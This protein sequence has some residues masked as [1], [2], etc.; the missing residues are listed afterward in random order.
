LSALASKIVDGSHNPPAKAQHG[1]PM[2]SA[3]NIQGEAILFDAY[4]LVEPSAFASEDRRTRIVTGDVLLTIVGAIGR[5]AVVTDEPKFV[6]QRS[7]AA[8]GELHGVIP[9]FLSKSFLNPSFQRWLSENAKGTAQRGV[10]LNKLKSAL[11]AVPPLAEQRRIVASLDS[12][13]AKSH[14]ARERLDHIPRL[15]E[16][17]KQAILAAAFEGRLTKEWR[18]THSVAGEWSDVVL[19]DIA[20]IQ[21]GVALG[22]KR[23]V[24]VPL[25]SR[26]YLRVANVQRG[27]LDLDEIKEIHVTEQEAERL[28]LRNGDILMNEG[29]DRDKL[30]RGWVW[31]GQIDECIHQN[32]VFRVRL[33]DASYPSKLISLYA[34]EFGQ[35]HFITKGTQTTNLASI[36]KSKLSSLPL[37]LPPSDEANEILKQIEIAYTWIDHL[38]TEVTS[39]R[40]LIDRLDQTVLSKAF[41]GEL[42]PQDP[43]DEPASALLERIRAERES[44]KAVKP[45]STRRRKA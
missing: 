38:A 28:Y 43:N 3:R 9:R 24:S 15:V 22:K 21:S 45:K 17:Y 8:I 4:R 10:Y 37:R 2:L 7:V 26:P 31:D 30:G 34:N 16:K 6:V 23:D 5:T 1:A 11:L 42:V 13:S 32:H 14:R 12:L 33:L 39:A 18:K 27:W 36:S 29:G 35:E 20:E 44:A 40:R 41:R 19:S 25:V